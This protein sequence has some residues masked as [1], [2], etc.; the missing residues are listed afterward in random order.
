[1]KKVLLLLCIASLLAFT[2]ACTQTP[3]K[4]TTAVSSK[5]SETKT[6][7]NLNF[8]SQN[9]VYVAFNKERYQFAKYKDSKDDII[10]WDKEKKTGLAFITY[11]PNSTVEQMVKQAK[12]K[13]TLGK[14]EPEFKEAKND[15]KID[16]VKYVQSTRYYPDYENNKDKYTVVPYL[17][18]YYIGD[19]DGVF[20]LCFTVDY[21]KQLSQ[22]EITKTLESI[23]IVPSDKNEA[24][25]DII[26]LDLPN[27]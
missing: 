3:V 6:S 4:Q 27:D 8:D 21:F 1:M 20:R 15:L 22:E 2:T 24:M 25:K 17:Y 5:E 14:D 26:L 9:S 7:S 18:L 10:L 23:S 16:A 13:I 12:D 11:L 19:G